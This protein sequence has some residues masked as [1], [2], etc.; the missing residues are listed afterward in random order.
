M[1]FYMLAHIIIIIYDEWFM[2]QT[3][4][5]EVIWSTY[6]DSIKKCSYNDA[7]AAKGI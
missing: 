3:V 2:L 7:G 6:F 5:G 1:M 4:F